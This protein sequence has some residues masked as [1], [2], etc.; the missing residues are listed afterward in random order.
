MAEYVVN[1]PVYNYFTTHALH[2][3]YPTDIHMTCIIP[4]CCT[5]VMELSKFFHKLDLDGNGKITAMEMLSNSTDLKLPRMVDHRA[6]IRVRWACL[7][8][9]FASV[10]TAV[11]KYMIKSHVNYSYS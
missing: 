1:R 3:I 7:I 2:D 10:I 4:A 9:H 11:F 6:F 5:D 8:S